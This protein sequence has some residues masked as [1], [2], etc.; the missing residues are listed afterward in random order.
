MMS[1]PLGAGLIGWQTRRICQRMS[2]VFDIADRDRLP[3]RFHGITRRM[4]A[5]PGG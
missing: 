4:L 2:R 3:W 1:M 5:R